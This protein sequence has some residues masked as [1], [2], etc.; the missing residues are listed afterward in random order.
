MAPCCGEDGVGSVVR[1]QV[2]IILIILVICAIIVII[3]IC[4]NAG[5][6]FDELCQFYDGFQ[7]RKLLIKEKKLV[8][9]KVREHFLFIFFSLIFT[10]TKI[11]QLGCHKE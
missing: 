2:V 10:V 8:Y 7:G 4:D 1:T 5:Q 3:L 6:E 11:T 9:K